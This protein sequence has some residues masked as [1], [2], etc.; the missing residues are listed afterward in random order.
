MALLTVAETTFDAGTEGDYVSSND[1]LRILQVKPQTLYSYVSRGLIRRL[2]RPGGRTSYYNRQDIQRLKAR[3]LAR[4]GHGPAAASAMHW[5]EPVLETVITEITP[6]GPRYRERLAVD[7][8]GEGHAF[9]SVAE[10][11]W[12]GALPLAHATWD[13]D[14]AQE[15]LGGELSDMAGLHFR[16]ILTQA[17]VLLARTPSTDIRAELRSGGRII[18]ALAGTLGFLGPRPG[19]VTFER[20]E[21]IAHG[22]AR[23]LGMDMNAADVRALN[24][25]LVLVADHELT[26][27][28]FAARISASVGSD[29]ESCI[30]AALQVHF[31]SVLGL[32]CDRLDELLDSLLSGSK[33]ASEFNPTLTSIWSSPG[34]DHPLYARGDPRAKMLIELAFAADDR[35]ERAEQGL[36]LLDGL[37]PNVREHP[38]L[39]EGLVVLCRSLGLQRQV[40]GSLLALGRSAGWIAHVIEQRTQGFIIRPR[41]KFVAGT[42]GRSG[43]TIHNR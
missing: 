23:A 17:A 14:Y 37:F 38:H 35:R 12:A 26:P 5:G 25:A 36:M 41:G 42:S 9:E 22:I 29:L 4:S 34:F 6:D 33:L 13:S 28:T 11:L 31:G 2:V 20:H 1:A 16:H 30:V 8:A 32:C 43:R 24:A 19:Y 10:Y 21:T 7:L 27:P 39:C 18:R 3:S 15:G 40:A